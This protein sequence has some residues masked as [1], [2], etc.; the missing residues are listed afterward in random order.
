M[1]GKNS[2]EMKVK[3]QLIYQN[4]AWELEEIKSTV[5]S[6]IENTL[7]LILNDSENEQ[8]NDSIL[9]INDSNICQE[10]RVCFIR[11]NDKNDIQLFFLLNSNKKHIPVIDFSLNTH[12]KELI[13]ILIKK[14]VYPAFICTS[15]EAKQAHELE[16]SRLALKKWNLEWIELLKKRENIIRNI[17]EIKSINNMHSYQSDAFSQMLIQLIELSKQH[18]ISSELLLDLYFVLHEH[19]IQIQNER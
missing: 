9:H 14:G 18:S 19:A 15:S 6:T 1:N 4:K 13:L 10:K 16:E 3:Y 2:T 7:R 8:K 5:E 12:S 11:I 17:F